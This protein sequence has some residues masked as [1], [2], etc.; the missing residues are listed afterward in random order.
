MN[1]DTKMPLFS[2]MLPTRNRSMIVGGAI[3]SV[4]D[5]TFRD[6][7]LIVSDNDTPPGTTAKV[8][9]AF[10]DPRLRYLRTQGDLPMHANWEYAL[11][12]CRGEFIIAL[13]D[14]QR[15]TRTA[16]ETLRALCLANPRSVVGYPFIVANG[17]TLE[18]PSGPVEPEIHSCSH[19]A[20]EFCRFS[21]DYWRLLPR[22]FTSCTPRGL[23]AELKAASPTGLVFSYVNPDH[24]YAF[25]VLS[26]AD[27]LLFV[28]API[29]YVPRDVGLG[30]HSTGFKTT[31]SKEAALQFYATV[32]VP[33]DEI[34]AEVPVKAVK[35]WVNSVLY[36]FRRFYRRA[37]H[38]PAVDWVGYHGMCLQLIITGYLAGGDMREDLSAVIASC[39]SRGAGF[40]IR[41]LFNVLKRCVRGLSD[42]TRNRIRY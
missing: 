25:Q 33:L 16:L 2:V 41:V 42:R 34:L 35:L 40:S 3:Q 31:I 26:R 19:V 20:D 23:M 32:P 29:A 7:E 38:A 1:E 28:D 4:L 21:H 5:Q 9:A 8:V 11:S 12:Q 17:N 37:G 10:S 22:G 27:R 15:L 24:A 14:K 13:E 18:G 36:D 39:K 6:F 30:G